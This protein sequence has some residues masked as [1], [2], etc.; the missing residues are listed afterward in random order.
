MEFRV[1]AVLFIIGLLVRLYHLGGPSLCDDE[2]I[3]NLRIS[4]SFFDTI[5]LLRNSN[6][7][8]LYYAM[9]NLWV[10]AWGHGEWALRFPS[11]LFS[12]LTILVIYKL[13][14]E[15]FNKN[16]GLISAF[17]LAFSPFAVNYAQNAKMYALFWFLTAWSFLFFFRFLK[18][19]KKITYPFYIIISILSCYTMYTGFLFLVTQSMI[20]LF[21]GEKIRRRQWF[22][23]QLIIL[24][25]CI[26]WLIYSL[27]SHHEELSLRSPDAAFSYLTYFL[28]A[29]LMIL[30][31]WGP[32][33]GGNCFLYVFL[34]LYLLADVFIIRYKIKKME[35]S[36]LTNYYC[37]LIWL[38]IP[39]F[40]YF[41]FDRFFVRAQLFF[42][43]MG[44]LQ[45]PLILIV[46]S[47]IDQFH[48]LIKR[49]LIL[50]MVV[51]AVNNTYLYFREHLRLPQEDWRRTAVELTHDLGKNDIVFSLV[52]LQ[53]F[54]YY[55]NGDTRRFFPILEKDCSLEYLAKKGIA[56]QDVHS[57]F[58]LY[59]KNL[60]FQN[61]LYGFSLV[62]GV[63]NGG[64]GFLHYQRNQLKK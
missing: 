40:L 38:I 16:V 27:S 22:S 9:L 23:G 30:G 6:F 20:F 62:D 24:S 58:I 8:P 36:L 59:K 33:R 48:G 26:P 1:I 29:F 53:Q 11:A 43:Y 37:L 61:K 52:D 32:L 45:V 64:I 44:F 10:R 47:Q 14:V 4:H 54:K 15:L 57:I 55:Y 13:G 35:F 63:W 51:M 49:M 42:R 39:V 25:F 46:S 12:G 3:T 50:V 7:P 60:D 17:L 5:G 28:N 34:L 31:G 56:T 2:L 21:L 41:I 19:Q 18:G